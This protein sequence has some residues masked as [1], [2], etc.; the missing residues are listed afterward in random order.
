LSV[1]LKRREAVRRKELLHIQE[2]EVELR[3]D[4][5]APDFDSRTRVRFRCFAPG[6]AT[7]LECGI[8][9]TRARLNGREIDLAAAYRDNRLHLSGLAADNELEV[10]GRGTYSTDG[11]G[12]YR[13]R[14]PVDGRTYL[15]S[16]GQVY[17]MHRVFACFDQPDLKAPVTFIVD[18]PP[19]WVVRAGA[20][21]RSIGPGRWRTDATPPLPT[22]AMA[23][24]A[25]EY[26]G[27]HRARGALTMGVYYPASR[28]GQIRTDEWLDL[29][30]TLLSHFEQAI[31]VPYPYAKYDHVFCPDFNAGAMENPGLVTIR[32]EFLLPV[33]ATQDRRQ[34]RA[35]MVAHEMAHMWFGNLVTLRWWDDLWLAE[36]FADLL[37]FDAVATAT[38][39]TTAWARFC[40][41]RKEWGYRSD[42]R[43]STHPVLS[44]VSDTDAA[45]T[46]LD[47]ITYAKGAGVLRQLMARL[48][49]ETFLLGLRAYLNR[50]RHDNAGLA[51]LVTA[52]QQA[53]GTDL[54]PWVRQ[55]LSTSGTNTLRPEP[56]IREGVYDRV[57]LLQSA[58]AHHPELRHHRVRIGLY[59]R[60]FDGLARRGAVDVEAGGERTVIPELSGQPAAD[61]L[62]VNDDDR[63][64]AHIGLDE[65]S[66]D[67]LCQHLSDLDD[68][69]ARAL[70]WQALFDAA[71]HGHL[72]LDRYVDAVLRAL[73]TEAD[74]SLA[75]LALRRVRTCLDEWSAAPRRLPRLHRFADHCL[76]RLSDTR[77]PF[78]ENFIDTAHQTQHTRLLRRWLDDDEQPAHRVLDQVLRWRIIVRLAVLGV[79]DEATIAAEA[80]RDRSSHGRQQAALAVTSQP[81]ADVK[82]RALTV[83]AEPGS[84][85]APVLRAYAEGLF[86]AEQRDETRS[87]L[88]RTIDLSARLWQVHNEWTATSL[89]YFL[90]P[91]CHAEPRTLPLLADAAARAADPRAAR[92]LTDYRF[93]MAQRIDLQAGDLA[94]AGPATPSGREGENLELDGVRTAEP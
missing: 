57:T 89:S 50:H 63:A 32:D 9:P 90:L 65:R 48:G 78:L 88:P 66:A 11:Q 7:F 10:E 19:H 92:V 25:G 34:F 46:H 67:A 30:A 24:V 41:S 5:D 73:A 16:Q 79:I 44:P 70:G 17:D 59:D 12:L 40:V 37:A 21:A 68:P 56:V 75:S 93:E 82:Q 87:L 26:L 74:G 33:E 15:Y 31:G 4:A 2:Y 69:L 23:L 85:S 39:F 13:H 52:L 47:G 84:T 94:G 64:W 53:G 35:I 43:P 36:A 61:L 76:A 91:R 38:P 6:A 77:A 58:P 22:Y 71:G 80:E 45:R 62:L 28:A 49:R 20:P 55:W 1:V 18:T 81:D 3:L 29:T 14:D 8:S 51:E 86:P 60:G 42:E 54:Q 72:D 27:A 83:L